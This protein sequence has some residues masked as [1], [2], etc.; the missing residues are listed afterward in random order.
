MSGKVDT[1]YFR[2][3][4]E[5]PTMLAARYGQAAVEQVQHARKSHVARAIADAIVK[6]DLPLEITSKDNE[7]RGTLVIE[8]AL[9]INVDPEDKAYVMRTLKA[10]AALA[11]AEAY[12]I[13][14]DAAARYAEGQG[15]CAGVI[16]S[17]LSAAA[18]QIN[19][20]ELK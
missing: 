15:G 4:E 1:L 3:E 20:W 13:V 2:V 17:A 8:Y 9:P 19:A 5:S 11:R 12:A 14:M 18:K 6:A 7:R 16:A 10:G